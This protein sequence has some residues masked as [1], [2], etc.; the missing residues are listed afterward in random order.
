M[1]KQPAYYVSFAQGNL[2][3]IRLGQLADF[4]RSEGDTVCG[5]PLGESAV[6]KIDGKL[7]RV[8]KITSKSDADETN[9]AKELLHQEESGLIR[10]VAGPFAS[11]FDNSRLVD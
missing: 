3:E 9:L 1:S 10:V 8:R 6:I 7:H 4:H 5:K 2:P 11:K